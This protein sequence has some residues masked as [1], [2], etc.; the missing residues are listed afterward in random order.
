MILQF[1]CAGTLGP[2]HLF[3]P[4]ESLS[5]SRYPG[6]DSLLLF[7]T[8][9]KIIISTP[10]IQKY[11]VFKNSTTCKCKTSNYIHLPNTTSIYVHFNAILVLLLR[12]TLLINKLDNQTTLLCQCSLDIPYF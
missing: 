5:P 1:L 12:T 11:L 9:H 8:K 7:K 10:Y 2:N 4:L 3:A 6:L